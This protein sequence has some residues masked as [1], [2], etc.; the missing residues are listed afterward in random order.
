LF[1]IGIIGGGAAGISLCMQLRAKLIQ[2]SIQAELLVFERQSNM[3]MGTAYS[4]KEDC[5]RVNL[6]KELMEPVSNEKGQFAYWLESNTDYL[7]NTLF[8]PRYFFGQYLESK[9]LQMQKEEIKGIK[10]KFFT[11]HNVWDIQPLSSHVYEIHAEHQNIPRIYHVN[12]LVL[13]LGDLPSSTFMD[14]KGRKGYY[15]DPWSSTVYKELQSQESLCIIGSK[16]TAID[17]ALKLHSIKY[18]GKI[19]MAS[20]SGLLPTVQGKQVTYLFKYLIPSQLHYF[21]KSRSHYPIR[22]SELIELFTKEMSAY[23]G[24]SFDLDAFIANAKHSSTLGRINA[25]IQQAER[26]ERHWY[27]ILS[28]SYQWLSRLWPL[29]NRDDRTLFIK[30][31][32]SIFFRY[33][34]S[35]PLE[36]AYSIRS[37]LQSGQ[38]TLHGGLTG[39]DYDKDKYIICF[40][41]TKPLFSN[42]VINA[43]GSDCTLTELPLLKNLLRRGMITP[44]VAGGINVDPQTCQIINKVGIC[45]PHAYAIGNLVK[46]ACFVIIEV[47]RISAQANLVAQTISKS[48]SDFL[49][50]NN[51]QMDH[52]HEET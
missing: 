2:A 42:Q 34:C 48:Y 28:V 39:I 25:D 41:T 26:G 47:G 13:C 38:L 27:N 51:N 5:Y 33:L 37:M 46:G 20:P 1:R 35:M 43:T 50:N 7:E 45:L 44:H 19:R 14:L 24:Y 9:A 18:Q 15:P 8:P 40:D 17:I 36:S 22:L 16:L 12:S 6:S 23:Y 31:Y 10:T 29:L 4:S 49:G 52:H 30:K 21:L 3:G 32:Q 11:H